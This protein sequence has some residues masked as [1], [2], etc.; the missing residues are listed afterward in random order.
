[1]NGALYCFEESNL[2]EEIAFFKAIKAGVAARPA[3]LKIEVLR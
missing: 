2:K 3:L 1:V